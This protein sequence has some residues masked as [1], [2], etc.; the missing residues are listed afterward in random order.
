MHLLKY[1]T[2]S[3]FKIG[4]KTTTTN[5]KLAIEGKTGETNTKICLYIYCTKFIIPNKRQKDKKTDARLLLL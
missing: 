1:L 3:T 4:P 2:K 5:L